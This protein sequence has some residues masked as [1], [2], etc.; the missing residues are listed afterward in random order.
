MSTLSELRQIYQKPFNKILH[1]AQKNPFPRIRVFLHP[2]M[3]QAT[4]SC[5]DRLERAWSTGTLRFP[6]SAYWFLVIIRSAFDARTAQNPQVRKG[7]DELRANVLQTSIE[8]IVKL[9]SNRKFM[10]AYQI[11]QSTDRPVQITNILTQYVRGLR[12][13]LGLKE[14]QRFD[15]MVAQ[16][17]NESASRQSAAQ[18]A[19]MQRRIKETAKRAR[20]KEEREKALREAVEAE[21]IYR[22]RINEQK[23]KKVATHSKTGYRWEV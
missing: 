18:H 16:A 15:A 14:Q 8:Q 4:R 13:P 11:M 5:L 7:L 17:Q 3:T 1:R 9:L 22:K 19:Y 23:K 2:A 20:E 10:S 6:Q 21:R 12:H